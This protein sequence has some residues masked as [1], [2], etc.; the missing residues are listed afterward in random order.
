M[1]MLGQTKANFPFTF[2][3]EFRPTVL[4]GELCYKINIVPSTITNAKPGE[5]NCLMMII[6]PGQTSKKHQAIEEQDLNIVN[7]EPASTSSSV[8]VYMDIL[9]TFSDYRPGS[10]AMYAL[11]KM[12]GTEGFLTLPKEKKKCQ[13]ETFELCQTTNYVKEVHAQC[14]CVPWS[15]EKPPNGKVGLQFTDQHCIGNHLYFCFAGTNPLYSK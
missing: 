6:D 9:G 8:R 1:T 2:C 10:F 4:E 11:K 7:L 13:V 5:K 12:T 3:S 14:G 15:L